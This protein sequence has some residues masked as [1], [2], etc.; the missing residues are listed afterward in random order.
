MTFHLPVGTATIMLIDV[1]GSTR[2]RESAAEVI[3]AAVTR[4]DELLDEA[5]SRHGG[6]RRQQDGNG[7]VAA[8]TRASDAVAAA[9]DVQCGFRSEGWPDRTSLKLRMALHTAEAQRRD[10]GNYFGR[11]V[12]R[13]AR[14]RAVAHGGQVVL[15]RVTRDLVL[16]RLPEHAELTD[17]GVHRLRDLGRPEHVFGLVHPDLPS[18]FPPLRSLD[19]MPNN[20]PGEL[21]SFVGRRAELAQIG[22]PLERVRLLT[23]TGAG[24]CGKTRLALQAAAD[25]M[26]RHPDG[27]W[28]VELARLADA[29]LLPAAVISALGVREEPCRALLDTL[30]K[31]LRARYALVVLDNCEHL[32]TACAE[33]ADALLRACPSLTILAT[34]RA[35]L[36]VPGEITWP[37]PSMSLP[38]KPQLEALRRSDAAAL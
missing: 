26:D 12:N 20:L 18:E 33:L 7:V 24:G 1:E 37:V 31:H 25:A 29:T 4:H 10:E 21:T 28:W 11:A 2:V 35:P 9:L 32:L 8:F 22:D 27:V 23:L 13:C 6:V 38:A 17:L 34:S 30:V 15:S 19:T 5:I 16:D 3:G 14:L 36:G